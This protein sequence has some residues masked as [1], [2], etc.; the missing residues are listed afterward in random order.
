MRSA[1]LGAWLAASRPRTW[2]ASVVPV[3]VGLAV[4]IRETR[5]DPLIAVLTVAAALALQVATN[6]ANDYWD[7]ERGVD[8]PARVGPARATQSGLLA[9]Q[10]VRRATWVA[11]AL[12]AVAGLPLILRGGIVI[13]AVG[14]ASMAAAVAYSAGPRPLASLGLGEA[15]AFTFFGVVAVSGTVFLQTAA[16]SP[17]ALFAGAAVG[18]IAAAIMLVNNLRDAASDEATG[19]RTLV[20]RIGSERGRALYSRLLAAALMLAVLVALVERTPGPL[21]ALASAPL[22]LSESRALRDRDGA[23]LDPSLAATARFELVFGALL[24]LGLIVA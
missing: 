10:A 16:V 20:V 14:L 13:V 1:R 11:L 21:L 3:I 8:G 9:A 6:L 2:P 7:S 15:L 4:A 18:S 19:K 5:L 12:A 22:A 24:A 23:A 17:T